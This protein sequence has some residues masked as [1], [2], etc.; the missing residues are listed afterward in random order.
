[1]SRIHKADSSLIWYTL[2]TLRLVAFF[3]C[4]SCV[5]FLEAQGIVAS[6]VASASAAVT[7]SHD[8]VTVAPGDSLAITVFDTPE[9]SSPVRVSN[10]GNINLPLIGNIYVVGLSTTSV[11]NLIRERL[12]SG[13]F[14]KNPQVTVNF[15][16]FTNHNAVLLGEVVH[17]G[18]VPLIGIRRLWETI[19]EAGGVT[20]TAGTRVTILRR[21]DS[22]A[23]SIFNIDWNSD[24]AG[25][26]NPVINPGDTIQISRAGIV[27]VLGEVMRQGGYSIT[28]QQMTASEAIALAEGIKYTSKASHAQL[29]RSTASGRVVS[30]LNIPAIIKGKIPD[31]VLK[32]NDIIYVPNSASKVAILRGL[33]AAVGITSS[34]IVYR[35][36]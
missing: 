32:D 12:I 19:G 17:P 8:D 33:Q 18:P 13:N 20:P 3:L 24:L 25:Q 35:N 5:S 2:Q 14:L 6:S 21:G 4:I 26:P 7:A 11:A 34:V 27:Y 28:H 9:F 30:E 16:D 29:V 31:V 10:D 36:Q 15:E 1:M 23:P 22:S